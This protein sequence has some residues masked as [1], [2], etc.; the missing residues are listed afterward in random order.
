[1]TGLLY[2]LVW[3]GIIALILDYAFELDEAEEF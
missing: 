2:S 1:M 3:A